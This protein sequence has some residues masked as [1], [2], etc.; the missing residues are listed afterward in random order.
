MKQRNVDDKDRRARPSP[1]SSPTACPTC[2]SA[3]WFARRIARRPDIIAGADG[4]AAGCRGRGERVLVH[5]A[6]RAARGAA[7]TV[8]GRRRTPPTDIAASSSPTIRCRTGRWTMPPAATTVTESPGRAPARFKP[9]A[10]LLAQDG[11][12]GTSIDIVGNCVVDVGVDFDFTGTQ[13][14]PAVE[15]WANRRATP[16]PRSATSSRTRRATADPGGRYALLLRTATR[17]SP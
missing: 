14:F 7:A 15:A 2:P 10:C 4:T 9:P 11:A 12:V 17:C 3:S 8:A 13:A 16:T 6:C 5:T 1:S